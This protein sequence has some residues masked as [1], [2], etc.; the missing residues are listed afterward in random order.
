VQRSVR[1]ILTVTLS[2]A[3]GWTAGVWHASSTG[4]HTYRPA[5][6]AVV[7]PAAQPVRGPHIDD[8]VRLT[9]PASRV[10]LRGNDVSPAVA[11]YTQDP[12][13]F[14]VE[15]HAPGTEV[16]RLGDPQS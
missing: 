7:A 4:A 11:S 3:L 9:P 1:I 13:G 14:L 5:S 2:P 12:A 8:E 6:A 16:S 15:E 10:D